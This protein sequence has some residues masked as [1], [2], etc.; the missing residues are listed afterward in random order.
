MHLFLGEVEPDALFQSKLL[1]ACGGIH[2]LWEM[3]EDEFLTKTVE[4]LHPE[5]AMELY[6]KRD[7]G[8]LSGK[9]D[10][11]E[12]AGIGILYPEHPA[13][14]A[15]LLT[16]HDPPELLYY[17]GNPDILNRHE[18]CIG[19]VGAREADTYGRE[20]AT[21]FASNLSR[22]DVL[23]VSG[24][25]KGIDGAAH[26][27]CLAADGDTV[28]VLGTGIDIPSPRENLRLYFEIEERGLLLSE[29][30]PGY[31][32]GIY[33]FPRRNRIISGI[34]H[35]VF[36]VQAR[37]RS[38][39]LIT[40]DLALEQ[41]R[42]VYALPGRAGDD[43]SVGCNRLIKQGALLVTTPDDIMEDLFG[44]SAM[45]KRRTEEVPADTHRK[46]N[47]APLEKKVYSCVGLDP[48]S[49]DDIIRA[50]KIGVTGA[51]SILYRLEQ[52][53]LVKQVRRGWYIITDI[54]EAIK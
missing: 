28:A 22:R 29:Y 27:G 54:A 3:S 23:I 26:T 39:S 2:A 34:S 48:V 6:A 20:I 14:P 33:T 42:Q 50:C 13:Y 38:G 21:Y 53:G 31:P 43:R 4:V 51:I 44:V 24:L 18:R 25:A 40:A 47:L 12:Q 52:S 41:G 30:P 49:V 15:Q 11:Y 9:L 19:I 37:E 10:R 46:N 45:E 35:G 16:I 36:V 8:F 1:R 17:K 7:V 5:T 32:G